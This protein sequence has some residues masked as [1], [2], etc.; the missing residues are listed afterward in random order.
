MK[1]SRPLGSAP[2][3]E[4]VKTTHIQGISVNAAPPAK[5]DVSMEEVLRRQGLLDEP[6]QP[7]I[8]HGEKSSEA[9]FHGENVGDVAND[10]VPVTSQ[11]KE[12]EYLPAKEGVESIPVTFIDPSPFQPR[13]IFDQAKLLLLADS[14]QDNG[15]LNN[16]IVVRRVGDRFELVAGERRWR[17]IGEILR[18]NSIEAYVRDLSDED[19]AVLAVT[20]NDAHESLTDF[21]R[22]LSYKRLLD[23]KRVKNQ[24]ILSRRVGRSMATISRC[25][26]YFKLPSEV[27]K[28]LEEEPALIGTK[29]VAE[30]AAFVDAGH[31]DLVVEAAQ[32]VFDTKLSQEGAVNW[33]KQSIKKGAHAPQKPQ[34][35]TLRSRG[36]AVADVKIQG[37]KVVF[38]CPKGTD[39]ADLLAQIQKLFEEPAD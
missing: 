39:P 13:R 12:G 28:M 6:V 19:A 38:A 37:Q 1:A 21:E 36:Q 9:G 22:G 24:M 23:E 29:Y 2:P 25:L 27:L 4:T 3:V 14:I 11:V 34:I 10:R 7:A 32:L 8:F 26:A 16:P 30:L 17:S 18:W 5:L 31:K 15:G 35:V 20:D 33:I